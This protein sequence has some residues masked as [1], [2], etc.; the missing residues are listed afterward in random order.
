[1]A[2]IGTLFVS[3][4]TWTRWQILSFAIDSGTW[5]HAKCNR[6]SQ[7]VRKVSYPFDPTCQLFFLINTHNTISQPKEFSMFSELYFIVF[8]NYSGFTMGS[9]SGGCKSD[10]NQGIFILT[11]FNFNYLMLEDPLIWADQFRFL[12][13]KN[14]VKREGWKKL[15]EWKKNSLH[16]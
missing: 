11:S 1:M 6:N 5:W 16:I 10:S 15:I 2:W 8:I 12:V 4:F 3:V 14:W 7:D 13:K 9:I